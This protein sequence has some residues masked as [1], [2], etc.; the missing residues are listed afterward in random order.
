QAALAARDASLDRG[1]LATSRD[2]LEPL[3][4]SMARATLDDDDD[5]LPPT[6]LDLGHARRAPVVA[7]APRA[8]PD[9]R[10]LSVRAATF[11]LHRAGFNVQLDGFG[12]A[13]ATAPAAG[14]M[15]QIGSLVRV[16]AAQ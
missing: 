16:S 12:S 7:A 11:A 2:S 4:D 1:T 3:A 5:T 9:V 14:A 13:R 8:V 15:A 6:I 10:G